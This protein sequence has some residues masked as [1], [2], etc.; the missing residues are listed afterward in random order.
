MYNLVM[1]DYTLKLGEIDKSLEYL[2]KVENSDLV[3]VEEKYILY[4][5]IY[6][7]AEYSESFYSTINNFRAFAKM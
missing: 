2:I 7:T 1:S 6:F 4:L 5:K 3:Y